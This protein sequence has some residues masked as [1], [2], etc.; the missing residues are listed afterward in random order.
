MDDE[1]L[2]PLDHRSL[3]DD[4]PEF[5]R[6]APTS[7]NLTRLIWDRLARRIAAGALS[8]ARLHK[9][10]V[11]ETARSFFEYTGE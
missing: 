6:L 8:G 3:N 5:A 1:V 2:E 11:R 4:V 9:V 7:E 10:V